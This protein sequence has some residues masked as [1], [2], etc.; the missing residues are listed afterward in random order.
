ML[1][2][3]ALYLLTS[4]AKPPQK[5]AA[6]YTRKAAFFAN[7]DILSGEKT[8]IPLAQNM[9]VDVANEKADRK[10]LQDFRCRSSIT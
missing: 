8:K 2:T 5:N 6:F 10:N 9:Y 4:S 3:R 1:K 7:A